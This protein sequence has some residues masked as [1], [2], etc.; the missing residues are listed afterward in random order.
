[1][2][3]KL[4]NIVILLAY[5]LPKFVREQYFDSFELYKSVLKSKLSLRTTAS[6]IKVKL[7]D[8]LALLDAAIEQLYQES[9]RWSEIKRPK[10]YTDSY[11]Y[12]N[13]IKGQVPDISVSLISDVNVLGSTGAILA[14]NSMFHDELSQMQAQHDLKR[15]DIF[16]R[17][18][19][20][21][22]FQLTVTELSELRESLCIHLLK[23]HATN[24]YHWVTELIP[25]LIVS[26]SVLDE[27]SEF[28][29]F[30]ITLLV[31]EGM[32]AQCIEMLS[33]I[34]VSRSYQVYK[35]KR[36]E[37]LKCSRLIYCTPLWLSLDNTKTLPNPEKEFFVDSNALNLVRK[38]LF[39][40]DKQVTSDTSKRRI[41]LQRLNKGL[42]QIHNIVDVEQLLY[43]YEFEFIDTSTM[44]FQEQL[45]LFA[46]A[47]WV[48]GA[49][50]AAHTNMLFMTPETHVISFYPSAQSTNYYVF[51]PLADVA[52]VDL[53][54][55]L[56]TPV[57]YDN[58]NDVHGAVTIDVNRLEMLLKDIDNAR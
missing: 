26:L 48:I 51:Q 45:D 35:V 24:Y 38:A 31:D 36:A 8:D 19:G 28:N 34:V 5:L 57:D 23:E 14:E 32:P 58:D 20:S 6:K 11:V 37:L 53:T 1:M 52:G 40:G 12:R 4:K 49:S 30:E 13:A 7:V 25:R 18:D 43:K 21:N 42:R 44:S 56:T 54:H 29:D 33:S 15:Q 10:L 55:F 22:Q 39:S 27:S 46:S 16:K 50:G 17:I 41:Y 3:F 9:E 47:D 2:N